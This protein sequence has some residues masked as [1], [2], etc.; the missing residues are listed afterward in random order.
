M[1]MSYSE[2]DQPDVDETGENVPTDDVPVETEDEDIVD[3]DSE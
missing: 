3:E 1:E 2:F